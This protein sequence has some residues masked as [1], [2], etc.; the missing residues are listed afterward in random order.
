MRDPDWKIAVRVLLIPDFGA[1]GY[2]WVQFGCRHSRWVTYSVEISFPDVIYQDATIGLKNRIRPE[3]I[4]RSGV[5]IYRCIYPGSLVSLTRNP[6]L[7]FQ[8]QFSN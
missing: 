1:G 5:E 3:A 8:N 2:R 6:P 7:A 4:G